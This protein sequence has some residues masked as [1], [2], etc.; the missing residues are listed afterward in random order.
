M[1]KFLKLFFGL[2]GFAII[3]LVIFGVAIYVF[4]D[5]N[6]HKDFI[7]T[8]VAEKTGRDFSLT[9]D[10]N[11]TFYPWL[12]V[13]VGG[14][15]LGNSSGFGDAPFIHTDQVALRVK[16]IPL[17]KSR[18]EMDTIRIYGAEINLAKN[19]KG[20]TN[21]D[22]LTGPKKTTEKS[23]KPLKLASLALGGVDIKNAKINWEDQ[24]T[25]LVYNISNLNVA[26]GRLISGEPID[27]SAS[28]IAKTNKPQLMADLTMKGTIAYDLRDEHYIL[29]PFILTTTIKGKSIQGGQAEAKLAAAVDINLRNEKA[30]VSDLNL[31]AF[32]TQV[33]GDLTV[34]NFKSAKPAVMGDFV[35]KGDDLAGLFKVAEIEPLATQLGQFKDRRFDISTR[36]D[37]DLERGNIDISDLTANLL[38]AIINGKVAAR[39]IH[40][41]TPMFTGSLNAKGPDLPTLLQVAGQLEGGK[42]SKLKA[43]GMQLAGIHEKAFDLS[44]DFDADLKTGNIDVSKLSVKALDISVQGGLKASDINSKNGLVDGNL[45]IRG[46]KLPKVLAAIGQESIAEVL[47]SASLNMG[48]RGNRTELQVSP[49]AIKAI[50]I[51]KAVSDSPMEVTLNAVARANLDQQVLSLDDLVLNGL[52]LDVKGNIQATN[53]LAEP[54]FSG[55]ILVAPFDLTRLMRQLNQKPLAAA[56]KNV[57][58]K[59]A[60]KT[61]F[62]GTSKRLSLK[63]LSASL[64]DTQ[65]KGMISVLDFDRPDIQFGID[66]DNLNADRYL[67]PKEKDKKSKTSTPKTPEGAATPLPIETLQSLKVKGD[68]FIGKLTINN[69]RMSNVRASINGKDGKI[70]LDPLTADLYQGK[71]DGNIALDVTGKTPKLIISSSL[72]GIEAEPLLKDL[73]QKPRLRGKGDFSA[74][75]VT[76]GGDTDTMKKALNGQMSFIFR[77]GALIGFNIGKFLRQLKQFGDNYSFSVKEQEETDFAE[78]KG[79]PTAVNGVVS[80]NDLYGKSP[81]LRLEGQGVLA[82]LV[83]ETINYT[84]NVTVV[85]TSKGQGGKEL[86]ELKGITFP[87]KIHGSLNDPKIDPD[88]SGIVTSR[89]KKE[90][91]KQ[92]LDK[93]GAPTDKQ[94]ETTKDSGVD[95]AVKDT[96]EDI[97]KKYKLP[98]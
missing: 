15:T 19:Q 63:D 97:K 56:D 26:T 31:D 5:P 40:S 11:L 12:G 69:A 4:F 55:D 7:M 78:L 47:Q 30:S 73:T 16:L 53:I 76:A 83:K 48:I 27:L 43:L 81:A 61:K 66:I 42:E 44:M 67:P 25:G 98:F 96:L 64:D 86:A 17:L 94:G 39:D 74:A 24:S 75:L 62:S 49:M 23:Q 10:I 79:N 57:F 92:V 52:G 88:I 89:A 95:K 72:K 9:G 91:E 6:D 85:E 60:L 58:R 13:E 70:R 93:I 33:Q 32:G 65:L 59:V 1:K 84:A 46:E 45:S 29:K 54:G 8:K 87:I 90:L 22:D 77:N 80:L 82:N 41:K 34:S 35:V 21:W 36:L 71:H 37:A 68:L 50:L 51:N 3:L 38:G 2:I 18:I 20:L 28:L 14:M